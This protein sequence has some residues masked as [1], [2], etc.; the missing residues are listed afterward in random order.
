M[1]LVTPSASILP[2]ESVKGIV[3]V[4]VLTTDLIT[5]SYASSNGIIYYFSLFVAP[6]SRIGSRKSEVRS[7]EERVGS[8]KSKVGSKNTSDFPARLTSVRRGS[9]FFF[10]RSSVFGLRTSDFGLKPTLLVFLNNLDH[11]RQIHSDLLQEFNLRYAVTVP[12]SPF[13]YS[14]QK[15]FILILPVFADYFHFFLNS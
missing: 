2:G 3:S 13:I 9:S 11:L 4:P 5:I 7:R 14:I 1:S 10:L 8:P 6:T 15:F 12:S